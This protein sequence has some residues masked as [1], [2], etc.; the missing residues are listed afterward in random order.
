V[1]NAW[2]YDCSAPLQNWTRSYAMIQ[3]LRSAEE[4]FAL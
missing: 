2:R 1:G 3:G 4:K